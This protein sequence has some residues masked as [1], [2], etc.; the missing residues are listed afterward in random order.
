MFSTE[1]VTAAYIGSRVLFILSLGGLSKQEN[2]QSYHFD[3]S[4]AAADNTGE[5]CN[6]SG[7]RNRT[8]DRE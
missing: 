4:D 8:K 2:A 7:I 3:T 1:I 5:E 6:R